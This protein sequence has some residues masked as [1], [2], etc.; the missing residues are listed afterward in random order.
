MITFSS[1]THLQFGK[2]LQVKQAFS[3]IRSKQSIAVAS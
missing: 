3:L 2:I 1:L